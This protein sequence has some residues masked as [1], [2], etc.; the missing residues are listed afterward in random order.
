MEIHEDERK[1]I[2][3]AH[4][5]ANIS[6]PVTV[7]PRVNTKETITFCCGEPTLTKRSCSCENSRHAQC[8]FVLSQNIR[9][10]IPI[11]FSADAFVK[12]PGINCDMCKEDYVDY[13]SHD[14]Y[15]G[16]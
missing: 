15:I 10:E 16:R 1:N 3:V 7:K 2:V 14:D 12:E 11:E 9:I 8:S 6:V 4:K 13:G 5:N